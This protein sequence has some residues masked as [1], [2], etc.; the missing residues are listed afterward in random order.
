MIAFRSELGATLIGGEVLRPAGPRSLFLCLVVRL[1]E[2]WAN[3]FSRKGA[4]LI[5]DNNRSTT[6]GSVANGFGPAQP[7]DRDILVG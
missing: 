6:S 7:H 1:H 5:G 3:F 4:F 2:G